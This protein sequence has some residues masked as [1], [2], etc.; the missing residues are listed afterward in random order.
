MPSAL[1]LMRAL[2]EPCMNAFQWSQAE[3]SVLKPFAI[4]T[5]WGDSS[6]VGRKTKVVVTKITNSM[7]LTNEASLEM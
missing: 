2:G 6:H 5:D 7:S 3:G 4:Y 1:G